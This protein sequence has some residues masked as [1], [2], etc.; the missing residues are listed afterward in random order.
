MAGATLP[1]GSIKTIVDNI[2][3][4]TDRLLDTLIVNEDPLVTDFLDNYHE[5]CKSNI[6]P[7]QNYYLQK[8]IK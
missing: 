1:E 5:W 3:A 4:S 7:K 8:N 2:A 6:F